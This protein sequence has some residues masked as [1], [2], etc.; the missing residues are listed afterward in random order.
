M[1]VKREH[2]SYMKKRTCQLHEKENM[3]VKKRK[4]TSLLNI[5]ELK[6]NKT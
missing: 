2:A 6:T 1:H 3:P 5:R 4:R